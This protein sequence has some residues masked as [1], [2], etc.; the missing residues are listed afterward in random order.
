MKAIIIAPMQNANAVLPPMDG[1]GLR[2]TYLVDG[3]RTGGF[4]LVGNVPQPDT[5]TCFVLVHTSPETV[6]TMVDSG[7]YVFVEEVVE[8]EFVPA[9]YKPSPAVLAILEKAK[10]RPE[11]IEAMDAINA[12]WNEIADGAHGDIVRFPEPEP[13]PEPEIVAL[14]APN[15]PPELPAPAA[16]RIWLIQQGYNP[17]IVAR[18]IPN[19]ADK[20]LAGLQQLHQVSEA[21]YARAYT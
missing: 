18:T 8:P 3:V 20:V 9:E 10:K 1:D 16:L 2:L 7:D 21:E 11:I 17:P 13:E 15:P 14:A 4:T 19:Q 5:F 12:G 6:D